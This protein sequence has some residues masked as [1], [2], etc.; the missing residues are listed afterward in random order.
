M[1]P[2][3][4][5]DSLLPARRP[6]TE[7]TTRRRAEVWESSHNWVRLRIMPASD[8]GYLQRPPEPARRGLA[9]AL[10]RRHLRRARSFSSGRFAPEFVDRC[11]PWPRSLADRPQSLGHIL[12]PL[13]TSHI[14]SLM[15]RKIPACSAR[16]IRRRSPNPSRKDHQT[17]PEQRA[18]QT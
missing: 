10:T 2:P 17:V 8:F 9:A 15:N 16:P 4:G 18:Q 7:T 11:A 1:E 5:L 13:R 6:A 12:Q 14:G 3:P